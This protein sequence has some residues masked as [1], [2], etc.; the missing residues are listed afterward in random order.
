MAT[1][2]IHVVVVVPERGRQLVVRIAVDP[3]G[4][5]FERVHRVAIVL[6][7]LMTSVQ[8]HGQIRVEFVLAEGIRGSIERCRRSVGRGPE[9]RVRRAVGRR[10]VPPG[11][12]VERVQVG[13]VEG[14]G[15]LVVHEH[16]DLPARFGGQGRSGRR[17]LEA[18]LRDTHAGHR[19]PGVG[20]R[21]QHVDRTSTVGAGRVGVGGSQTIRDRERLREHVI[22]CEI[23]RG[24]VV[25]AIVGGGG[26]LI[27]VRGATGDQNRSP[28]PEHDDPLQ[29]AQSSR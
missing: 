29:R 16:L 11:Q 14:V 21:V 1:G 10:R 13:V 4:A 12:L 27:R 15:E 19:L 5:W 24:E 6:R 17:S 8:V 3:G 25:A 26:A 23:T 18:P 7:R 28:E 9:H 2:V 20:T 22:G